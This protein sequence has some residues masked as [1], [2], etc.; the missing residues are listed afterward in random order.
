MK[1]PPNIPACRIVLWPRAALILFCRL[2]R[3]HENLPGSVHISTLRAPGPTFTELGS[4]K[5]GARTTHLSEYSHCSGARGGLAF[6][7]INRERYSDALCAGW[8]STR[9]TMY[10]IT[11][12]SSKSTRKKL[13]NC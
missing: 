13:K 7:Y 8:R 5:R 4:Q 6:L 1:K 3:S 12:N 11:R 2:R 10:A 9:L